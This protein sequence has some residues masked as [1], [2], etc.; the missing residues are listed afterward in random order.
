MTEYEILDLAKSA[1]DS[2]NS[3]FSLY[4]SIVSG[5]LIVAY[6]VGSNLNR[7][8]TVIIGILFIAGASLQAWAM[9][10]YQIAIQEYVAAKVDISPLTEYQ[11]IIASN[12]AGHWIAFL[13]VCGIIASLYFMWDIRHPKTN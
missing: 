4:L 10:A 6:F 3:S 7:V 9:S 11:T 1:I 2:M 12:H 5:Y 8:Q 13:M